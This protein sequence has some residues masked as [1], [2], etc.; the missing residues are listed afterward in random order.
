M[1][2]LYLSDGY[3]ANVTGIKKSMFNELKRRAVSVQW[4]NVHSAGYGVIDGKK[5]LDIVKAES[6]DWV[7]IVHS[8]TVLRNCSL[9]ELEELGA[10]LLKFGLSDPRGWSESRLNECHRYAT[11]DLETYRTLCPSDRV[12]YFP[13]SC[14]T[15]FHRKLIIKKAADLL[16]YGLGFHPVLKDYRSQ[17]VQRIRKACPDIRFSVVGNQWHGHA[18]GPHVEGQEFLQLINRAWLGVD[19]T[20]PGTALGRR[21]FEMPACGTPILSRRSQDT[22]H[23]LSGISYFWDSI[24][25]LC[26]QIPQILEDRD[27]LI[28]HALRAYKKVRSKHNISNRVD[29]LLDWIGRDDSTT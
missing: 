22:E 11:N 2:I 8:W 20:K 24:D 10:M 12:Y 13:P 14:D 18:T 28:Q 21:N 25:D 6:I 17:I 23:L 19:I 26:A 5:V 16:F 27:S 4:M 15:S 7:W 29:G 3:S 9:K 1:K